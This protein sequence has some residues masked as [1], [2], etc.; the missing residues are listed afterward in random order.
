V[1]RIL[2]LKRA[3]QKGI[4]VIDSWEGAVRNLTEEERRSLESAI[5][6]ELDDSKLGAVLVS[7]GER[8]SNLTHLVDGITTLSMSRLEG[9]VVRSIMVD[10]LRGFRL[11]RQ[12]ALFTLDRGRFTP[13][14]RVEFHLDGDLSETPKIPAIVPHSEAAYSTGSEDLDKLL[15]GGVKKG[16]SVLIDLN[17]TVSPRVGIILIDIITANFIN[18]GGSAFIV[19]YSIFSSQTV[20]DSMRSYVGTTALNERV[21]IAEYNQGL[22]DEEWRVKM[23]GKIEEDIPILNKCWNQLGAISTS[24]MMKFDFDKL[25]QVY[26]EAVG[27]PSL[28]EI[29]AGIRE[30]AAFMMAV[31]SRP[32]MMREELQRS[33]DYYLKTQ[34]V[35][36]SLLIYGIKPFS[37]VHGAEFSFERG[38]PRLSLM[39]IV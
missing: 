17:R 30:S 24:R 23:K 13:L 6:S 35:D 39:E 34:T 16:S 12:G 11:R 22:P 3:K 28:A 26:G 15:Q 20:A 33:V 18:Q 10:K 38:Y 2:A 14:P 37:N 8:A 32:T 1:H 9:R 19:P 25:A 27:V 36:E 7:E 29:G 21:R 5:F 4:V 31:V